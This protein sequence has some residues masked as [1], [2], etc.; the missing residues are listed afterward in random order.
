MPKVKV[1]RDTVA[2][3]KHLDAGNLYDLKESDAVTLFRMGRAVPHSEP[4]PIVEDREKDLD[5]TKRTVAKKK[6][7]IAGSAS[8]KKTTK[9]KS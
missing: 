4:P 3:G 1:L 2:S 9:K 7:T 8:V 5:V 6:V